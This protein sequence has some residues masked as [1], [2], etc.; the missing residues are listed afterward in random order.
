[1]KLSLSHWHPVSIPDFAPFLTLRL[2][3]IC[4]HK[5]VSEDE[6]SQYTWALKVVRDPCQK[7]TLLLLKC[8]SVRFIVP[9]SCF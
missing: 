1:M 2:S 9:E 7:I 3:Y 5:L 8:K 6:L 4:V